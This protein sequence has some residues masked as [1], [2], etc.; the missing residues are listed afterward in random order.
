MYRFVV[1][2]QLLS[3][4][5]RSVCLVSNRDGGRNSTSVCNKMYLAFDVHGIRRV[6]VRN[7]TNNLESCPDHVRYLWYSLKYF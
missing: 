3:S 7:L 2:I 5:A 4:I 1:D 6:F